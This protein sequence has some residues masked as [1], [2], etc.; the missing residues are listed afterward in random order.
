MSGKVSI[1]GCLVVLACVVTMAV[2]PIPGSAQSSGQAVA[3]VGTKTIT[4]GEVAQRAALQ[5]GPRVLDDLIDEAVIEQAAAS[6][7]AVV[8][9][10]EIDQRISEM[11]A[12]LGS[13]ATLT[14]LLASIG[15]PKSIL[16]YR[17]RGVLLAEK[18]LGVT[19]TP[20]EVQGYYDENLKSFDQPAQVKLRRIVVGDQAAANSAVD[21]LKKGQ[22]FADV[23]A[24]VSK[25]PDVKASKGDWGWWMKGAGRDAKIEEV[26]FATKLRTY[27]QPFA[28]GGDYYVL[29]VEEEKAAGRASFDD[30]KIRI[31][32]T[33]RSQ[34]L[35]SQL[36]KWLPEQKAKLQPKI[37][38]NFE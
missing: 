25:Y 17:V 28:V 14:D 4:W 18:T 37:L 27:S 35:G 32:H 20:E 5:F 34:K 36:A 2:L 15:I 22:S 26:A 19:V 16:R 30:V 24:A 13:A 29:Y 21:R 11:S 33:L 1:L 38:I 23:S 10:A 7:G 31:T 8:S 9:D 3:Q 6:K 12:S